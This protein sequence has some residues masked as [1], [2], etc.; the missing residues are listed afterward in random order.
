M[1]IFHSLALTVI[2]WQWSSKTVSSLLKRQSTDWQMGGNDN[3]QWL[4][5][6]GYHILKAPVNQP[7]IMSLLPWLPWNYAFMLEGQFSVFYSRK[8]RAW[9][10]QCQGCGVVSSTGHSFKAGPAN[11]CGFLPIQNVLWFW[12][13]NFR[14]PFS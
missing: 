10:W 12:C 14:P 6:L 7:I 3:I 2:S 8:T 11:P 5:L 9:C 4:P 1:R 13:V